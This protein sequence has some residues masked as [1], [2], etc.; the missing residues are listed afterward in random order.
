MVVESKCRDLKCVR[1]L[2]RRRRS[3]TSKPSAKKT[4]FQS[5]LLNQILVGVSTR[6]YESSL[7]KPAAKLKSRG[8][9]GTSST[10]LILPAYDGS[11]VAFSVV[12]SNQNLP[13]VRRREEGVLVPTRRFAEGRWLEPIES[14]EVELVNRSIDE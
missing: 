9:S 1:S 2:A 3:H 4:R 8:T 6:N 12:P 13:A 5:E 7:D 14:A 10:H 11:G